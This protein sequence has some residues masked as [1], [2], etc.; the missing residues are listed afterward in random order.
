MNDIRGFENE[1][2]VLRRFEK[3]SQNR[4]LGLKIFHGTAIKLE[5]LE[6]LCDAFEV[7]MPTLDP[8]RL[9]QLFKKS[10]ELEIDALIIRQ[11]EIILIEVK[12]SQGEW[13]KAQTQL[14]KSKF[15]LSVLLEI[16][17][18]GEKS[19]QVKKVFAAPLQQRKA[20][21]AN[22]NLNCQFQS[23]YDYHL[24]LNAQRHSFL[25]FDINE[26]YS[27]DELLTSIM[28]TLATDFDLES[29]RKIFA[30]LAFMQCSY[31]FPKIS[32]SIVT[33]DES[34]LLEFQSEPMAG[35]HLLQNLR[36]QSH[37][38]SSKCEG[39]QRW[40]KNVFVWLDPIQK[41][42]FDDTSKQQLIIGSAGTGKTL[43]VQLKV[44]EMNTSGKILILLPNDELVNQY[45]WFFEGKLAPGYDANINIMSPPKELKTLL[46][47][48]NP[49]H[50]IIDE[51]SA[52]CSINSFCL[53]DIRTFIKE[54]NFH[55]HLL[56]TFDYHQRYVNKVVDLPSY[57]FRYLP[58][59]ESTSL[60]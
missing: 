54:K 16:L 6:A 39:I 5:K 44:L 49:T 21:V 42:F 18:L 52:V 30:A 51:F 15:L 41:R 38:E 40:S 19:I 53:E 57:P 7:E 14:E 23:K 47:N 25:L 13:G 20:D 22:S 8:S 33:V 27:D 50:I 1:M 46:K 9:Q 34:E 4:N 10:I 3:L 11:N 48:F 29:Q 37:I 60:P 58:K 2:K 12:S 35:S 17:G 36:R 24:E 31:Y 59:G 45:K 43:L 26:T 32:Q 55:P 56:I 28:D